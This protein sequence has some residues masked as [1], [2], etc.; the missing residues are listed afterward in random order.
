M[1]WSQLLLY[2]LAIS[3]VAIAVRFIWVF[4]ATYLPRWL[5]PKLREREPAP[6]WQH[7]FI[8]SFTGIRG[9]VSLAAAL[10]IPLMITPTQR[11][12]IAA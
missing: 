10:S 9:V 6:S 12:Q 2:A 3:V 8:V 5:S 4:P 7:P 1:P 11:F